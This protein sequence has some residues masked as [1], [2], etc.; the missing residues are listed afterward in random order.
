MYDS[1]IELNYKQLVLNQTNSR[2]QIQI[3]HCM[4]F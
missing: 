2:I 4:N 3:D 1:R